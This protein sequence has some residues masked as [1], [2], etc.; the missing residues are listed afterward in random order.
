MKVFEQV[1]VVVVVVALVVTADVNVNDVLLL[2]AR[3]VASTRSSEFR[4]TIINN[5]QHL[6][7]FN[8]DKE[9]TSHFLS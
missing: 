7:T 1:V 6:T 9:K 3:Q 4:R 5:K 8:D 2:Q